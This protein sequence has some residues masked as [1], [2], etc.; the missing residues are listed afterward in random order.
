MHK[1]ILAFFFL[2]SF[3]FLSAST[4][5]QVNT[6]LITSLDA[7]LTIS[8]NITITGFAQDVS[9]KVYIPQSG[10]SNVVVIPNSWSYVEDKLGNKMIMITWK[11]PSAFE[12]YEIKLRVR[13]DVKFF[14]NLTSENW[15]VDLAKKE[16]DITKVTSSMASFA[17]GNEDTWEKSIRLFK[18]L[19]QNFAYNYDFLKDP[20]RD[21]RSA[22]EVWNLKQAV[23]GEFG[24]LL[25][26]LLRSQGIPARVVYSYAF[27]KIESSEFEQDI[28]HGWAEVYVDGKWIPLD[29]TFSQSGFIDATHIKFAN[30]LENN[31]TES[32]SGVG[33]GK[34]DWKRNNLK[35]RI[36]DYKTYSPKIELKARDQISGEEIFLAEADLNTFCMFQKVQLNSC[37]S[38]DK[39]SFFE[40]EDPVRKFWSCGEQ[41]IFWI[42]HSPE[43]KNSAVYTC[44]LS[45]QEIGGSSSEQKIELKGNEKSETILI[46][47][48]NQVKIGEEFTLK[49]DGFGNFFSPNITEN[50]LSSEWVLSLKESG[51]HTFYFYSLGKSGKKVI[52]VVESKDLSFVKVEKP[53][54]ILQDDWFLVNVTIRNIGDSLIP[55][56]VRVIFQNQTVLQTSALDKGQEKVFNFNI[57]A[58]DA[59]ENRILISE[60]TTRISYLTNVRV[61]AREVFDSSVF[62][63]LF[64]LLNKIL[65]LIKNLFRV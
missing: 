42:V 29:V 50:K 44:T 35:V 13:N 63:L 64:N 7:E 55:V 23:S 52:D 54:K 34:I 43:I 9:I 65:D 26:A 53:E 56:N 17:S 40:I 38:S 39:K 58:Y 25:V 27:P 59:G 21:S 22:I 2:S 36:I 57:T 5:A 45:T 31:L 1:E 60:E 4:F 15:F 47:G 18:H 12:K 20:S 46:S 3:I 24:N 28:G 11:N 14:E 37:V 10:V 16:T 8:G 62:D 19:E 30:L 41:K 61:G 48:P 49:T 51:L 32:L 6:R 33:T